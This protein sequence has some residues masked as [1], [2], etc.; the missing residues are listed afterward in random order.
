M[1]GRWLR[2]RLS[3]DAWA[4]LAIFA[5]VLLA[6]LPYLLGVFDANPL[7]PRSGLAAG[8]YLGPL[9]GAQTIDPN[10]G[11]VS[12]ALSHRAMLD[13]VHLHLPWWNPFEGTGAPLAGEMQSAA[14]FPPTVLTL[15]SN[16]QLYEHI[17]LELVA[18]IAT[19]LLLRRLGLHRIVATGAGIAFALN[20]TFAWF[21]HATV[22]PIACLPL[23]LLGI[24]YAY[25]AS[26]ERR[27][28]GWWLIAVAGVLSVTAGFPEV[29]YIDALLGLLWF[30]WRCCALTRIER[31]PML[32]KGAAGAAVAGLLAAPLLIAAL[33]YF[34]RANLGLHSSSTAAS[35]HFGNDALSQLVLPYVY[36][37]INDYTDPRLKV[38]ELWLTVGGFLSTSLL[39]LGSLG[40]VSRGRRGLRITLA[41]WVVLAFARMYGEP[42]GLGAILRALP[43]MSRVFFERYGFAS[44]EFAVVVLAALGIDDLIR[45]PAHRRRL[46]WSAGGMLVVVGAAF[47]NARPLTQQL[48][49]RFASRPYLAAAVAWGLLVVAVIGASS[50]LRSPRAMALTVVAVVIVD[51]LVLFVAPEASAPRSVQTDL[52]PVS[53]LKSH[54]SGQRF[55]TLG[56]LAPNYG[57][58]FGINSLN[59][60]DLP[61]P[62]VFGRFVN[63]RLDSYVNPTVFVG[64]NGGSRDLLAPSPAQELLGNL[65]SYRAAG[66]AYVLTP[67][68]QRLPPEHGSL[69]L[70]YR[71]ASSWIYHLT[72]SAPYFQLSNGACSTESAGDAAVRVACPTS[73]TLIRHETDL[74]GWSAAVDGH[75]VPVGQS[76]GVFQAVSVRS[77]VHQVTF[78]YSPPHIEW[79]YLGFLFGCAWLVVAP[80]A[81]RRRAATAGFG[82]AV[83]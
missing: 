57:S 66:V 18:G 75:P 82:A 47:L 8:A 48:G 63:E 68:G 76:G 31:G 35:S 79:G 16:G 2:G 33:D 78:S 81:A 14:F 43:G 62:K 71:S 56:P 30:V 27:A 61:I 1:A 3:A 15:L 12:Q 74:P 7:G 11:F 21:S 53:F 60:N 5:V 25:T 22:N 49:A 77:G 50:F 83:V 38:M 20:G 55:F 59:I 54:L 28:G 36:G 13:L 19:F 29:A 70:V 10:N 41:I 45:A 37:P 9:G 72:G 51:S 58:Y 65:G 32:R 23:L 73:V 34:G 46:W 44:L 6:N 52:A 4:L 67:A 26:L 69:K 80:L 40:L 17:L 39:L 42:P 24:E 64:N